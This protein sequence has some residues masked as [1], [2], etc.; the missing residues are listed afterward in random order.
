MDLTA[1]Q[2][3]MA[4]LVTAYTGLRCDAQARDQVSPPQAVIVPGSP[5]VVF[6]DTMDPGSGAVNMTV[7]LLMGDAPGS[8]RS[9]RAMN[10][11][12]GVGQGEQTSIAGAIMADTTLAGTADWCV[13]QSVSSFGRVEWGGIGYW[14]A[15]VN[16]KIATS[17]EI[18][19]PAPVYGVPHTAL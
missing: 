15:K 11:Y 13:P 19:I 3:A 17:T 5:L 10:D 9:I 4:A 8:D 14:G 12:L 7:M 2:N 6:G 16:F 18:T 1:I